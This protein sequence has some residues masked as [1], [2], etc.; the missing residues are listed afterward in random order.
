MVENFVKISDNEECLWTRKENGFRCFFI[1]CSLHVAYFKI[2]M[3][4]YQQGEG[5]AL[6]KEY[7]NDFPSII[8][9]MNQWFS[10]SPHFKS[11][12]GVSHHCSMHSKN[13][14]VFWCMILTFVLKWIIQ[15]LLFIYLQSSNLAS[16]NVIPL[17]LEPL[18]QIPKY[19]LLLKVL[20]KFHY[21]METYISHVILTT[22]TEW[23]F[24]SLY[25]ICWSTQQ[26]ITQTDSTWRRPSTASR[27]S[28]TS[29][30]MTL[31]TPRSSSTSLGIDHILLI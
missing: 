28:S 23:W 31:N 16:S 14:F 27:V 22:V 10:Q 6:Y 9:N 24:F 1:N 11:L 26:W 12:M 17:L 21:I 25:R 4:F 2:W 19:S 8:N 13:S 15:F 30:T 5:L 18:Q 7:I 3:L 20:F 29:W